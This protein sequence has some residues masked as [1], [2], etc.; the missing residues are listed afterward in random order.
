LIGLCR[1]E[2][3]A[4]HLRKQEISPIIGKAQEPNT[5]R[6]AAESCDIIVDCHSDMTD[7]T[8]GSSVQT[9]LLDILSKHK[10]IVIYTSG[11]WVYGTTKSVTDENTPLNPTPLV[12]G[13]VGVEQAYLKA[14]AIVLR[15]GC[16]YGHSGSLAGIFFGSLSGGKGEFAGKKENWY[17]SMIHVED[18]GDAFVKAAQKGIKGEVY[19][20]VSQTENILDLL[21][22]SAAILGFKGTVS[23]VNATD[24]FGEALALSQAH[25][26]SNKARLVLGWCPKQAPMYVGLEKYIKSWQAHQ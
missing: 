20:L 25:I 24:P 13:R 22:A 14:G 8:A 21:H 10:K 26:T 16:V 1:T 19:N 7:S 4:K 23:I 6:A 9:V 2:D 17:W 15:P 12:A 3:K 18:V 5:W 11:V